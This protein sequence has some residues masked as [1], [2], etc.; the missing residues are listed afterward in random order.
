MN[1]FELFSYYTANV[2]LSVCLSVGQSNWQ[3]A[4]KS[5]NSITDTDK[6]NSLSSNLRMPPGDPHHNVEQHEFLPNYDSYRTRCRYS[7]NSCFSLFFVIFVSE[8]HYWFL[9]ALFLQH[10]AAI[11]F[12]TTGGDQL[13]WLFAKLW[14]K[15]LSRATLCTKLRPKSQLTVSSRN[16]SSCTEPFQP[17]LKLCDKHYLYSLCHKACTIT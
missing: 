15:L 2:A 17:A 11:V 16:S 14:T 10:T 7:H 12:Q 6:Q 1:E 3:L 9:C 8:N 4:T 13:C 5:C